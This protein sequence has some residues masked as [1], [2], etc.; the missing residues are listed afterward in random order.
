MKAIEIV[1]LIKQSNPKLLG[2]ARDARVAKIISAAFTQIGK[3]LDATTEGSVKIPA[4][5]VFAVK[6]VER[7]KEGQKLTVK[8]ISFRAMKAKKAD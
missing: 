3:Q 4:L 1:E 8:K 2:K 5:G 7:E 6:Q